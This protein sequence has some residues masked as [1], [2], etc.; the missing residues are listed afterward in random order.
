MR[1]LRS[2]EVFWSAVDVGE[3]AAASSGD[4]DFFTDALCVVEKNDTSSAPSRLDR[5]HHTGCAS[6][7]NYDINL[8]HTFP[9]VCLMHL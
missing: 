4:K 7:Q 2:E 1:T 8:L 3:V 6:S 9:V 5:A